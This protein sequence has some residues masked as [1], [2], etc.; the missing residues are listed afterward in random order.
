MCLRYTGYRRG[1]LFVYPLPGIIFVMECL[2][3]PVSL[4]AARPAATTAATSEPEQPGRQGEGGEREG[5][6][7]G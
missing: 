2:V 1:C 3:V 6:R 4:I 5:G 7:E